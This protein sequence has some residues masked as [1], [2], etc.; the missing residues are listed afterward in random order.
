M[1]TTQLL[2]LA[3]KEYMKILIVEISKAR[4]NDAV[5]YFSS[6][7]GMAH[8]KW[9]GSLPEVNTEYEV[10]IDI[11]DVLRWGKDIF[12]I[13]D[14]SET[15]MEKN[16][17]TCITGQLKSVDDEYVALISL[18]HDSFFVE[19]SSAPSSVPCYVL[20]KTSLLQLFNSNM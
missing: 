2:E 19:L 20:I 7:F 11:S 17:E 1:L 18:A 4:E 5:V 10:E 15:L 8:G 14:K 6:E 12:E 16:G 9:V 3:S 13:A